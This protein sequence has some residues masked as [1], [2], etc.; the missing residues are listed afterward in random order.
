MTELCPKFYGNSN[1]LNIRNQP[2][3][4]QW[5]AT[6]SLKFKFKP[7]YSYVAQYKLLYWH[8]SVPTCKNNHVNIHHN[9]VNM[10]L[11]Y[12]NLQNKFVNMEHNQD[13]C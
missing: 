11:I 13:T 12:V 8:T 7:M 10:N 1:F 4:Q 9:K 5:P 3:L 6:G 2:F